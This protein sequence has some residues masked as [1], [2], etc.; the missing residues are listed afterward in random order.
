MRDMDA[1]EFLCYKEH[2]C[3]SINFENKVNT[4]GTFNCELNNSTHGEHNEDLV[5]AKHYFYHGTE[6]RLRTYENVHNLKEVRDQLQQNP[7]FHL[8]QSTDAKCYKD[9]KFIFKLFNFSVGTNP[10]KTEIVG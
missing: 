10:W 1:C 7:G 2:N 5:E 8:V 3:V 9:H 6:V 4:E